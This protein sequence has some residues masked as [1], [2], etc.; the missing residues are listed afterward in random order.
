MMEHICIELFFSVLAVPNLCNDK[1][2]DEEILTIAQTISIC[3]FS[4]SSS[5]YL[6]D[7]YGTDVSFNFNW[8]I[9]DPLLFHNIFRS[10]YQ[11]VIKFVNIFFDWKT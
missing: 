11:S 4:S 7:N 6:K 2:W 10:K 5:G 9:T 1:F 3:I 8:F